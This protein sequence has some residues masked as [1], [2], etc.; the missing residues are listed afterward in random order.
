MRRFYSS[1]A[2]V[3]IGFALL[4]IGLRLVGHFTR[5]AL[6]DR[7]APEACSPHP[8][9]NGLEPGKTSMKQARESLVRVSETGDDYRF[10][11]CEPH[12]K[13]CWDVAIEGI[14]PKADSALSEVKLIPPTGKL[15]L[16]DLVLLYGAPTS[17]MIC[18]QT[19][20]SSDDV[21][22][23]LPRPLMVGYVIFKGHVRVNVYNPLYPVDARFDPAMVVDQ[24]TYKT[25][26]D[27]TIPGWRGFVAVDQLG[28]GRG[29]KVTVTQ[30][31]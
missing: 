27:L 23:N 13:A 30:K 2:M 7:F 29:G 17:A 15:T 9:W 25:L 5:P 16:G 4:F 26:P 10:V 20:P 12:D 31:P 1:I 8:C 11:L 14:S 19:A 3:G 21:A 22:A 24:I 6:L 28:C 18:W